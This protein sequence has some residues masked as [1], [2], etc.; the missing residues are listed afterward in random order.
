MTRP[1]P[2]KWSPGTIQWLIV[3][4]LSI[5]LVVTQVIYNGVDRRITTLESSGS[6]I[7]R[8]RI[9]KLENENEN[10]R[11][12]L[13]EIKQGQKEILQILQSHIVDTNGTPTSRSKRPK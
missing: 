6:P 11:K 10:I 7:M 4:F 5:I 1:D 3:T 9:S 8:E 2:K 12:S 13:D